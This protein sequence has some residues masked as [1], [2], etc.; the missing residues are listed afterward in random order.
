MRDGWVNGGVVEGSSNLMRCKLMHLRAHTVCSYGS[1]HA[2]VAF[3]AIFQS[4]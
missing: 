1:I 4:H 3:P 2:R